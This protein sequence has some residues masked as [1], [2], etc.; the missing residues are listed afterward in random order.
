[1]ALICAPLALR[2]CPLD[3]SHARGS[4]GAKPAGKIMHGIYRSLYNDAASTSGP[5]VTPL[6]S[7]PGPHRCTVHVHV[8]APGAPRSLDSDS[9]NIILLDDSALC[10]MSGIVVGT[11]WLAASTLWPGRMAGSAALYLSRARAVLPV[12][13]E[14]FEAVIL[15]RLMA[16]EGVIGETIGRPSRPQT[17]NRT[18]AAPARMVAV[19]FLPRARPPHPLCLHHTGLSHPAACPDAPPETLPSPMA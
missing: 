4:A 3:A 11:A 6:R 9:G 14:P 10:D 16:D 2:H 12:L 7:V 13:A 8:Q 19:G 5:S 1:M 15:M 17:R 18:G